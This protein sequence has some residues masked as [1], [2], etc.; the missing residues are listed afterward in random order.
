MF[1]PM[2]MSMNATNLAY[3]SAGVM[4]GANQA[5]L[6]LANSASGMESQGSVASLA[7]QDKALTLQGLQAQTNYQVSQAM[8]EGAE[9]LKKKH[10][11][12][13]DRLIANGAIFV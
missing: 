13:N 3:G 9:N 12:L 6:D 4:F 11:E 7:A 8:L 10:K 5:R 1:I 2:M